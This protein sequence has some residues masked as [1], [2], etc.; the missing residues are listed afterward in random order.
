MRLAGDS[1][2]IAI[3]V[4]AIA[5]LASVER[6]PAERSNLVAAGIVDALFDRGFVSR[7]LF[8]RRLSY[9]RFRRRGPVRRLVDRSH[10]QQSDKDEP[11]F[12]G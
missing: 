7:R 6:G 12:H 11:L 3:H 5:G 1:V 10:R 2:A 8:H 4:F 9:G